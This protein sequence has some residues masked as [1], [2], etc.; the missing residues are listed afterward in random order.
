MCGCPVAFYVWW[1]YMLS[2]GL[3][4]IVGNDIHDFF[5]HLQAI[6]LEPNSWF[7]T[8]NSRSSASTVAD[9]MYFVFQSLRI[10]LIQ[11]VMAGQMSA[12]AH[13]VATGCRKLWTNERLK[14]VGARQ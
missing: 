14:S 11:I 1:Y 2:T 5:H 12:S 10:Y 9:S 8:T 6:S 4:Y 13:D 3:V 7:P